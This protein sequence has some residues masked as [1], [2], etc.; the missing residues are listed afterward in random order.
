MDFVKVCPPFEYLDPKELELIEQTFQ[1]LHFLPG[2]YIL[3]QDGASS[4]YFYLIREGVVRF[5]HRG[6]EVSTAGAGETFGYPSM[7]LNCSPRLDAVSGSDVVLYAIP[8][9]TF[10]QLIDNQ[11]FA[12]FFLRDLSQQLHETWEVDPRTLGS[13]LARPVETLLHRPPA[14]V[15]PQTPIREVA[16]MMRE[17]GISSVLVD[18]EELGIVT[19]KAL[20]NYV[21]AEGLGPETL[22]EQI[23]V[24]PVKSLPADTPIY[25]ALLFMIEERVDH[26]PLIQDEQITGIVTNHDLLRYQAKSPLYL[27]QQLDHVQSAEAHVNYSSEIVRTVQALFNDG[28]QVDQIGRIVASLNDTLIK[29]LLKMTEAELGPPP[30]PYAWL[31]FGSEGRMEQLLLTDQDN[32]LVYRD[33]TPEARTYFAHLAECVVN[34]LV[35][36]GFPRCPGGYMA[37]NWCYPLAHWQT[38]FNEWI[39][40]PEPQ[41]LLESAIFFDFRPV[42]GTLPLHSLN[43]IIAQAKNRPIFLAQLAGNALSFTPPLGF[44]RGIRDEDGQV[45]LKKGGIAPIVAVARIYAIQMKVKTRSTLERLEAAIEAGLINRE[46]ATALAEAF[47]YLQWLRLREQF[48]EISEGRSPDNKIQLDHLL[49]REKRRLREALL[50][51]RDTQDSVA[52]RFR[53]DV[54]G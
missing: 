31:V 29:R 51:I 48:H 23:M 44:F 3:R 54:L 30:T 17:Q 8:K 35:Q 25:A 45:D 47:R 9:T 11:E 53:T 16:R 1:I 15:P 52:R 5:L 12:E 33:D 27:L 4:Q 19:I 20:V 7:L 41:A 18:G 21:L 46:D 26:L 42:H 10:N 14:V 13:E 43:Q 2:T 36:A 28:L 32:A 38:L 49:G 50:Y 34:K 24:R 39:T 37:T 22:V 6:E 40:K